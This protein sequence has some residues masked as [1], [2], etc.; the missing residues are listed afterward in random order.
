MHEAILRNTRVRFAQ[1]TF[2]IKFWNFANSHETDC[3]NYIKHDAIGK[4]FHQHLFRTKSGNM[5][6]S[7]PHGYQMNYRPIEPNLRT[8][9][10]RWWKVLYVNLVWGRVRFTIDSKQSIES[11]QVNLKMKNVSLLRVIQVISNHKVKQTKGYDKGYIA[12][13]WKEVEK[14][15]GE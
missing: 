10:S 4:I 8:F 14:W 13:S 1:E 3:T 15:H 12:L 2:L 5:S 6:P 11:R 7:E 9:Q